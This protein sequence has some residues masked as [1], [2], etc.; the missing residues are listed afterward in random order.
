MTLACDYCARDENV[1]ESQRN[2]S[3]IGRIAI[4]VRPGK[5]RKARLREVLKDLLP[6]DHDLRPPAWTP[7][8]KEGLLDEL[9]YTVAGMQLPG[10]WFPAIEPPRFVYGQSQGICDLF[11]ACV[12]SQEDDLYHVHP[13][14]ADPAFVDAIQS[15][16][17]E[18]S[19]YYNV[20]EWIRYARSVTSGLFQFYEPVLTSP[21]DTANYL[22][23]TT[24]LMEWVY[25]EPEILHRLLQKIS[26]VLID[27]ISRLRDAAGGRVHGANFYCIRNMFDFCSECRSLISL[28]MY[29][30]FEAPYLR[31]IGEQ[32]GKFGI[33]SCGSWERTVPSAVGDP[34]FCAMN[35]QVRENDLVELCR[36]ADGQVAL[37]IGDSVDLDERYTW[38]DRESFLKYA[39]E[40]IPDNQ[41]AEMPIFEEEI[42]LF[43]TVFRQVKGYESPISHNQ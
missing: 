42:D 28:E 18:T 43:K 8:W 3:P 12:E 10:D 29:E 23:G 4:A 22:L 15:Q 39:L 26:N 41:P 7:R 19:I 5:E 11:G 27:V 30:E 6:D 32:L 40:T 35:G 14:P 17:L 25:T 9:S 16:P 34:N 24:V 21:F 33:H 31:R 2:N 37:G 13:L 38:P 36:L 1:W 20:V